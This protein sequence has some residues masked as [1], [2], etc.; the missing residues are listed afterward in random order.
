M[1]FMAEFLINDTEEGMSK[2]WYFKEYLSNSF[3]H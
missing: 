3:F 1:A 2:L